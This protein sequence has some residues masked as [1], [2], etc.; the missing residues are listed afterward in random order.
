MVAEIAADLGF[1]DQAHFSREFTRAYGI[2]PSKY[3]RQMNLMQTES[4]LQV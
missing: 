3:R 4:T 1:C 2:T